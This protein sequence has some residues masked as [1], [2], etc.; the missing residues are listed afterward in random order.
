MS[1][2]CFGKYQHLFVLLLLSFM[3]TVSFG[4][5]GQYNTTNWRFSNPRPFG[6][7]WQDVDFFDNNNVIAVGSDGGI[8]FSKDGGTNWTYGPYTYSTSANVLTKPTFSD[9]HFISSTTAYAVGNQ[10]CMVKTTDGGANWSFVRT[11]LYANNR[12]INA[13]WFLNKDTGYIGGQFNTPDSLPKLYITRNGGATWD[14]IAAPAA[15]GKSRVGY[16]NNVNLPSSVVDVNAKAKEIYRIEFL[17]DSIGYVCGSASSLFPAV[18]G[19]SANSTTCLPNGGNLTGSASNAALLWKINKG[20][21]TDYSLSKERLGYT[22]INTNTVLCTT[23]YNSAGVTPVGQ[24]YRAMN[25]LNDSS[26]ILMSFNNNCVVRVNTG[27]NDSILNVNVAGRYEKGKYQILNFPFPPTGGPNAGPPIPAV[28]VLLASNPYYMKR[29]SNGKLYVTGNFGRFFTSTDNGVNWKQEWSLPQG[30]NFSNNGT[31]AL[32]IAP[33]GK[34]LS[35]GS[36]GV[37]ADSVPGS[38]WK[39]NYFTTP[40]SAGYAKIDF[41]D[42]NNGIVAGS[43][44]ITV[45]TDGGA[46]WIDKNRPDF[47]NSFYSINGM[48]YPTP[49]KAYF[50]VSNGTLYFSSDKGTTLDPIYS[51]FNFQ[52]QDVE[53]RGNNLWVVGSSQ[54]SVPAASRT[55]AVFRSNNSGVTWTPY[56]GFPVGTL[57]QTLTDIEFPTDLIGYASG[58]RDTIYK[59]TN[60]GGTWTK[61]PLPFPGVTPQIQYRDMQAVDANTVVLCG[62]GF[63]R[64][65][66]IITTDGGATWRDITSNIPVIYPVGNLTGV[67]FQDANNGY[68]CGPGGALLVT[69]NGGTSWR[70]ELAPTACLN[71]TI[72][73]APRTVPAGTPMANR[74]LFV[75]GAN[76]SGAP[77]MEFGAL[78]NLTMSST[79]NITAACSGSANGIVAATV[80]GGVAPYTYSIDNGPV[81]TSGL[82]NGIFPGNHTLTVRDAACGVLTKPITVGVRTT[83]GADAGTPV[84]IISGDAVTLAGSGTGTPASIVWTPANSIVSGGNTYTPSVKP[85]TTT[86]YTMT[87]TDVNGCIASDNTVVTVIPYCI[88]VMD[89]FTPNGDGVNDK[90]LVTSGGAC[91]QKVSVTVFNR[92]GGVVYKNENYQNDWTGTFKGKS[93]PDGTYYYVIQFDLVNSTGLTMKGDLTILR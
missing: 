4:Q 26:V 76:I 24:T 5:G 75:T 91:T 77:L 22:G 85:T 81:Q 83:P 72:G 74:K 42:C 93:V 52:M 61:L 15:N 39:T 62:I 53:A 58:N 12:S 67:R 33:N 66:V 14:S 10:G 30:K 92:Y 6:I 65:V 32:D 48:A 19:G 7:T 16:I 68:V 25:I 3:S 2:H 31:W 18:P 9:V 88:K 79:E 82:F 34:F 28:Q 41:A 27:K 55:S 46:T 89:A 43:S 59:T 69:N 17:N 37:F 78:A 38:P 54:F 11:P 71:E 84:T 80:T 36:L 8:A 40:A 86:T 23:S 44:N 49:D 47:A 56:T 51:N 90:W 13:V 87:V 73:F 21:I 64:K 29:A 20:V 70:L 50:A 1:K 60:G 57:S 63:P 35:M 45:T